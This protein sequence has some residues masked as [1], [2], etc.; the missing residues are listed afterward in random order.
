MA[1]KIDELL[2]GWR[3]K[4]PAIADFATNRFVFRRNAANGIGDGRIDE[5]EAII[6]P[7]GECAAR[8]TEFMERAIEQVAGIV[9]GE[10]SPRTVGA[11]QARRQP[12]EQQSHLIDAAGGQEGR[13]RR[14]VPA[15]LLHAPCGDEI[16]QAD[17]NG[18]VGRGLDDLKVRSIINLFFFHPLARRPF[19]GSRPISARSDVR[20]M[21]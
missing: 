3:Q 11:A 8:K 6:G 4:P 2:D 19:G 9:A 14:I 5:Y 16:M 15:G 13:H 18:A 7:R 17:A 20:S 1:R 21:K 10:W 12:D